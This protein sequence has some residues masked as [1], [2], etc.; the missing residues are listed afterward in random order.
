LSRAL[1][2]LAQKEK[3]GNSADDMLNYQVVVSLFSALVEV[4]ESAERNL[5]LAWKG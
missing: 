4:G 5:I 1:F 2:Y 3:Y